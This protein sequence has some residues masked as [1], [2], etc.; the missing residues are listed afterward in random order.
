M[1]GEFA[2]FLEGR[3]TSGAMEGMMMSFLKDGQDFMQ[4]EAITAPMLAPIMLKAGGSFIR[5]KGNGDAIAVMFWDSPNN[6]VTMTY[7]S[8]VDRQT[9]DRS[10]ALADIGEGYQVQ[11]ITD[12]PEDSKGL[13][14]SIHKSICSGWDD[15]P[16]MEEQIEEMKDDEEHQKKLDAVKSILSLMRGELPELPEDCSVC[17][18]K[19]TCPDN[20]D[21]KEETK[22]D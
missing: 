20:P 1:Q 22:E 11:G 3:K 12:T 2:E 5:S 13:I 14:D 19:D 10:L 17:P 4:P 18:I 16:E 8:P 7:T 21:N 15:Q 6:C 9:W